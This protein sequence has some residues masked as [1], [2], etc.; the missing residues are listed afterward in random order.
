M[1]RQEIKKVIVEARGIALRVS[2]LSRDKVE[3]KKARDWDKAARQA[4]AALDTQLEL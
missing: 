1:T 3:R 4:L 2:Y